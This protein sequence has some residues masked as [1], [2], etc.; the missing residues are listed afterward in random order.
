M[1]TATAQMLRV[2]TRRFYRDNSASFAASRQQP[3]PGWTRCFELPELRR[4]LEGRRAFDKEEPL[5]ILDLACGNLRFKAFLADAF[6]NARLRYYAVD[7]CA[8][9]RVAAPPSARTA[10]L[11]WQHLDVLDALWQSGGLGAHLEAPLCDL[12]VCFGFMHHVPLREQ[13]EALLLALLRQTRPGGFVIVSFWQFLNDEALTNK[14]QAA[15]AKALQELGSQGLSSQRLDSRGP[16][17]QEFELPELSPQELGAPERSSPGLGVSAPA[18]AQTLHGLE[19]PVAVAAQAL[20]ELD[21]N[22]F[23]LGWKDVPGAY[24]YCHSFSDAEIDQLTAVVTAP[25]TSEVAASSPVASP[26]TKMAAGGAA[27]TPVAAVPVAGEA[28]A[29]EMAADGMVAGGTTIGKVI[30]GGTAADET[31][32]AVPVAGEV[33]SPAE[34]VSHTGAAIAPFFTKTTATPVAANYRTGPTGKNSGGSFAR[35][36]TEVARFTAD[37]RTGNLNSYLLLRVC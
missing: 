14:A 13:R 32:A 17:S 10:D 21:D 25:A 19:M 9:L 16:S 20:Q 15:H 26:L 11:R 23:L 7:E 12:S 3:W 4:L 22:D 34:R 27:T 31:V 29:G 6:P 1:N 24:R 36:V 2:L 8:A 5:A 18:M 35:T 30:A 33:T 37:G 28:P